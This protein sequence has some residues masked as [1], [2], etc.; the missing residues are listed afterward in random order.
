MKYHW[1]AEDIQLGR[2]IVFNGTERLVIGYLVGSAHKK[3]CLIH[4]TDGAVYR[5]RTVDELVEDLNRGNYEPRYVQVP[6][7]APRSRSKK[8]KIEESLRESD[9]TAQL[10]GRT[11]IQ[12]GH[13]DS[14]PRGEHVAN[15]RGD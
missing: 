4:L 7:R 14:L 6:E 5:E 15:R 9:L 2:E 13:H 8:Q 10:S 11:D 1:E 12:Y 3:R